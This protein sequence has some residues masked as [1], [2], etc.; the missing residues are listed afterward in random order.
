[1]SEQ[2]NHIIV[3]KFGAVYGI[4]GWLK[5]HSYTDEPESL[6]EYQPWMIE[7]K[8]RLQAVSITEYRRHS[9][10][11]IAKIEGYDVRENSQALVGLE[12]KVSEDQ[13]P[14][15]DDQVYWRDLVGCQVKTTKGYDLGVVSDIM[16]TGSNDVLVIKSNP[17][18]AFGKKERLIPFLETQVITQVDITNKFIEVDWDPGF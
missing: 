12:I 14:E 17:T 13:L 7:Q 11:W 15:L 8:G 1:M 3:G 5:I 6:F 18:D 4:K 10:S 2:A 9:K 16:E